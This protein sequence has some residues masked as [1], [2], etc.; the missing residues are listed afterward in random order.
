VPKDNIYAKKVEPE[1]SLQENTMTNENQLLLDQPDTI[2]NQG[3][4][5]RV[6]V[7]PTLQPI[8]DNAQPKEHPATEVLLTEDPVD[9]V[10]IIL[11]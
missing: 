2:T 8:N 6:V 3:K 1:E 11:G 4:V 7:E 10:T 5:E 9:G